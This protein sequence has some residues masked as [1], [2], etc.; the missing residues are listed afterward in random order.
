MNVYI[1]LSFLAVLG[2][3]S[4]RV[5]LRVAT[6]NLDGLN[7]PVPNLA[8]LLGIDKADCNTYPDMIF[9]AI[10]GITREKFNGNWKTAVND[11]LKSKLYR[12]Y[13]SLQHQD[14]GHFIVCHED[15]FSKFAGTRKDLYT[16]SKDSKSIMVH[17][18]FA[19]CEMKF[20]IIHGHVPSSED[21]STYYQ[22]LK[23][24]IDANSNYNYN[25]ILGDLKDFVSKLPSDG[26]VEQTGTTR[27]TT[28][29]L[30]PPQ[31]TNRVLYK[32][33]RKV[34]LL[35]YEKVNSYTS[36]THQPVMAE[37]YVHFNTEKP[38]PTDFGVYKP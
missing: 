36:S 22:T 21:D 20:T 13:G 25:F 33:N 6:W 24:K 23:E 2:V 17:S 12:L 10:Q 11:A 30:S 34:E 27:T 16:P 8:A 5:K 26:W 28:P 37:Y 35:A 1:V 14:I 19:W 7:D 29:N 31:G 15:H 18:C 32:S 3:S 4:D 38:P 9:L